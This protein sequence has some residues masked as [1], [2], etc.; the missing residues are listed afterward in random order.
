MKSTSEGRGSRSTS[1]KDSLSLGWANDVRPGEVIVSLKL[2]KGADEGDIVALIE[3][4]RVEIENVGECKAV[5][6]FQ[7]VGPST[8]E[9]VFGLGGSKGRSAFDGLVE[10]NKDGCREGLRFALRWGIGGGLVFGDSSTCG[11]KEKLLLESGVAGGEGGRSG[12]NP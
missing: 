1:S 7:L 5:P 3:D 6:F 11:V 8:A 4:L 2:E 10:R 12:G 9:E